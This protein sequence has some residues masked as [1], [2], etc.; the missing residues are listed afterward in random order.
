MQIL[1]DILFLADVFLLAVMMHIFRRCIASDSE[2][3]RLKRREKYRKPAYAEMEIRWTKHLNRDA[4]WTE[5][6]K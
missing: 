6:N 2:K 5:V 4:L 3:R 1:S